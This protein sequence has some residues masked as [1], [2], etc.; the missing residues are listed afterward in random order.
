MTQSPQNPDGPQPRRTRITL[1]VIT[2]V[3][4]GTTR[5]LADWLLDHLAT[6]N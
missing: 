1:A 2:G 6:G 5:A 4:A 3:L